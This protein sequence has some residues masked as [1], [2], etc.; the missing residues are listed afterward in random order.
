MILL[1]DPD[2]EIRCCTDKYSDVARQLRKC[3]AG[4]FFTL[5][6][7]V[8]SQLKLRKNPMLQLLG[9]LC[10]T[11]RYTRDGYILIEGSVD[12]W[13]MTF[14]QKLPGTLGLFAFWAVILRRLGREVI[15]HRD[16]MMLEVRII[17]AEPPTA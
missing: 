2:G 7:G 13:F 3:E 16:E 11:E 1:E 15:E 12:H 6:V 4:G 9:V 8:K 14:R 5:D 10:R 17:R